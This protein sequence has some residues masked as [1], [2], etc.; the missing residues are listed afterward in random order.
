MNIPDNI[1]DLRQ[2]IGGQVE[3]FFASHRPEDICLV[4]DSTGPSL[5]KHYL[6]LQAVGRDR[7]SRVRE[8]HAFSGGVWA[9]FGFL[10][11]AGGK[12]NLSYEDFTTPRVE[13]AMRRF[14]H[15]NA[16]GPVRAMYRLALRKSAFGSA[17]PILDM[18]SYYFAGDFLEQ[19]IERFPRNLHLYLGMKGQQDPI[20]VSSDAI[21][22]AATPELSQFGG[23]PIREIIALATTVPFVYGRW[24]RSDAYFDAA[25]TPGYVKALKRVSSG[26]RPTLVSTPWRRGRKE[27]ITFVNCFASARPQLSMAL[28]FGRLI[29]NIPN[30]TFGHDIACAF[31]N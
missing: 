17:K 26:G 28:D 24:D 18:L 4:L 5:T 27:Q 12:A 22:Q 23:M 25:Y 29:L 1:R 10:A 31:L 21:A 6:V 2:R 8:I 13:S 9:Y 19:P 11:L 3:E 15:P 20:S 30:K 16:L 14:H 7:L